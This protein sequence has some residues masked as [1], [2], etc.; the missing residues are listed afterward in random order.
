MNL[1]N[2][3]VSLETAKKLHEAEIKIDSVHGWVIDP[4]REKFYIKTLDMIPVREWYPAPTAEEIK[5]P[6][7]F[8]SEEDGFDY[9]CHIGIYDNGYT[10]TYT[11]GIVYPTPTFADEK[12]CEV[13]AQMLLW[14]NEKGYLK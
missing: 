5:L 7:Y 1:E 11:D 13:K 4:F 6:R 14:L 12:E 9:E 8:V 2:I 10:I 3:C